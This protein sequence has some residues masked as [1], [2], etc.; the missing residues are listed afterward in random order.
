MKQLRLMLYPQHFFQ[1]L[2]G[3]WNLDRTIYTNDK[4]I[5]YGS[6]IVQIDYEAQNQLIYK[7]QLT[8][9]YLDS[10]RL[11]QACQ[12]YKYS[13]NNEFNIIT[14][15]FKDGVLFYNLTLHDMNHATGLH[16]CAND[17][18]KAEYELLDNSIN[19]TYF[20]S[21]PNKNYI[22]LNRYLRS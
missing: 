4:K 12:T 9:Q 21:G 13:I 20:V 19:L 1:S 7:E 15:S 10:V 6:G 18:Y 11:I 2:H 3:K 17:I 22:I 14:K 5:M 8:A 16:Q